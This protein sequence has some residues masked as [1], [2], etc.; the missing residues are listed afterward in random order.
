MIPASPPTPSA[1]SCSRTASL[2]ATR[3]RARIPM[4]ATVLITLFITA[5]TSV[6]VAAPR[7]LTLAEAVQMA[8]K[9]EPVVAEAHITDDRAKLG[10]LRAQLDRF[11]LKIDGLVQELWN[12]TN[13]GGAPNPTPSDAPA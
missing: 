1:S 11:S 5:T 4:R 6:A 10:V 3:P 12:K 9:V 2:S 8:M 13:I 7:R